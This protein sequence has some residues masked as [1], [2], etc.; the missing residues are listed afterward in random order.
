MFRSNKERQ[1]IDK[2]SRVCVCVCVCGVCVGERHTH[3]WICMFGRRLVEK[4]QKMTLR[5]T[6]PS[7]ILGKDGEGI[8]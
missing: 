6:K 7:R 3:I 8:R 4:V 5:T 2:I 1:I